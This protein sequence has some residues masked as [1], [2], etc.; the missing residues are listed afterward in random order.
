MQEKTAGYLC[1]VSYTHLLSRLYS[2]GQINGH[3][4]K[5]GDADREP[6][7]FLVAGF[8]FIFPRGDNFLKRGGRPRSGEG[9]DIFSG[10]CRMGCLFPCGILVDKSKKAGRSLAGRSDCDIRAVWCDGNLD[11]YADVSLGQY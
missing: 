10:N 5:F 8:V 1:P 3:R 2:A 11:E 9:D 7:R 6:W 4:G